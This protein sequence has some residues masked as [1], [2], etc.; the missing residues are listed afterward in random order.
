V[1]LEDPLAVPWPVVE[2]V[3][4]QLGVSDPSC[5]KRYTERPKTAYEH[6][7]EIRAAY[8]F[9]VFEDAQVAAEFRRFLAGRA[10]TQAEGL[11]RC[12]SRAP[13]RRASDSERLGWLPRLARASRT[14]ARVNRELMRALDAAALAAAGLD[15]AAAW[16]AIERIASRDEVD[17]A[18]AVVEELV[19]DDD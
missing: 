8:G 11:G 3:A 4:E 14:L 18:V 1:F 19:P 17:G 12:S 5:V 13:A 7:W 10:W 9:R 16:A 6:A 15:V 2:Y